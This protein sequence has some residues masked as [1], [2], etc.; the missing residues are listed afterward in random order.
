MLPHE[1]ELVQLLKDKPFA[2][3]GINSDLPPDLDKKLTTYEQRLEPVRK[4][5]KSEVLDK[6]GITWRNAIEC[7]TSGPLAT[8]WNIS[9]W[10]TLFVVDATGK[11]RYNGHD[12]DEMDRIVEEC[13]AELQSKPESKK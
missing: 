5:V 13:M 4:Y 9:G 7:G 8:K 1:K 11:I 12:G 6:N 10:P 2:L 3:L